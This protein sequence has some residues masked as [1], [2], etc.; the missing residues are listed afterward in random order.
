[1]FR[2]EQ[3]KVWHKSVEPYNVVDGLANRFPAKGRFELADQFR[4]AALSVSSNIAEGSG[5]ETV[6]E[7][8]YF[9]SVAKGSVFEMVSIAFICQRRGL[10]TDQQHVEL[11][12]QAEEVSEMLTALKRSPAS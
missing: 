2:C 9:L 7:F 3:A 12:S 4:H 8:R 1:M 10:I 6:K 5:R 11:Y